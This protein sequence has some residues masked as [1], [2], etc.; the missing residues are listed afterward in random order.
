M[1]IEQAIISVINKVGWVIYKREMFL[2]IP[3]DVIMNRPTDKPK[4]ITCALRMSSSHQK[5]EETAMQNQMV[6]SV[7]YKAFFRLAAFRFGD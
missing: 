4:S 2:S 6:L 5:Y 1:D 3:D 7:W